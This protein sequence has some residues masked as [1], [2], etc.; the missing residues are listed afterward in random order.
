MHRQCWPVYRDC[1]RNKRYVSTGFKEQQTILKGFKLATLSNFFSSYIADTKLCETDGTA[2]L[3]IVC[4]ETCQR[5]F[6]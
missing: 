1:G 2:W 3:F 4:V 5:Q 6:G